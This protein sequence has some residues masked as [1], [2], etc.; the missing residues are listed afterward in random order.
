MTETEIYYIYYEYIF[1]FLTKN[2]VSAK[3]AN[4]E[5]NVPNSFLLV[6]NKSLRVYK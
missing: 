6:I 2:L 3:E 1:G 4:F 5:R